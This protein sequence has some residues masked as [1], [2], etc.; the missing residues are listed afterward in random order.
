MVTITRIALA[1]TLLS[2]ACLSDLERPSADGGPGDDGGGN[3]DAGP[4]PGTPFPSGLAIRRNDVTADL[5]RNGATDVVLLDGSAGDDHAVYV[6]LG[7]GPDPFLTTYHARLDLGECD[8]RAAVAEDLMD[9]PSIDLLVLCRTGDLGRLVAFAGN[10]DGTFDEPKFHS[11]GGAFVPG[12]GSV[13]MPEP[14]FVATARLDTGGGDIGAVFG[15]IYQRVYVYVPTDWADAG[16]Q[17]P[18]TVLG[19]ATDW[20]APRDTP[21]AAV[22]VA[23]DFVGLDDILVVGN[24]EASWALRTDEVDLAFEVGAAEMYPGEARAVRFATLSD[25]GYPDVLMATAT[26][27]LSAVNVTDHQEAEVL[28]FETGDPVDGWSVDF[29]DSFVALDLGNLGR[30]E[31]VILDSDQSDQPPDGN[32]ELFILDDLY[33]S[34]GTVRRTSTTGTPIESSSFEGTPYHLIGGDFDGD[35][36]N[37]VWVFD[38]EV[39][40]PACYHACPDAGALALQPCGEPC[41]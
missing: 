10:G 18:P 23:G 32:F 9:D 38:S 22:A 27:Y 19:V 31:L 17:D 5:D 28:I 33:V 30:P 12:G 2:A 15:G 37:E 4:G 41:T 39:Q 34:G 8:P 3:G 25:D 6:V 7:D 13:E 35:A 40:A 36:T 20:D 21:N 1:A 26:G 24:G 11:T 14:V 16:G 29:A